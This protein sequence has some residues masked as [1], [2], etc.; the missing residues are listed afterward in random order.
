[1]KKNV[2]QERP[3]Q[4]NPHWSFFFFFLFVMGCKQKK[5]H[6]KLPNPFYTWFPPIRKFSPINF[7]EWI[8]IWECITLLLENSIFEDQSQT[9]SGWQ[10]HLNIR[11]ASSW[12]P[13]SHCPPSTKWIHHYQLFRR[14]L[15]MATAE[16][17]IM[18]SFCGGHG[19]HLAAFMGVDDNTL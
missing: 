15:A 17:H 2:L 9:Y 4:L 11:Y 5:R 6:C 7:P 3:K 16:I 18:G 14:L 10:E 1:M 19:P 8:R 12:A 13:L